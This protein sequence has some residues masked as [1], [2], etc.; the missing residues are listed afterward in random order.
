MTSQL[1]HSTSSQAKPRQTG[2]E[3]IL[4]SALLG[5][6]D[7]E[8]EQHQQEDEQV[9]GATLDTI[10]SAPPTRVND[11][12]FLGLDGQ[13]D[14]QRIGQQTSISNVQLEGSRRTLPRPRSRSAETGPDRPSRP[15]NLDKTFS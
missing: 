10:V 8:E 4:Q 13:M 1:S 5:L 9:W 11:S 2:E 14:R 3:W 6:E 15:V 7:D 12:V